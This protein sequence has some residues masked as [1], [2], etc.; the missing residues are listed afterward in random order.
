[1]TLTLVSPP[2]VL[3]V[4]VDELKA[5][6]RVT[7]GAED[8]YIATCLAASVETL[9]GEGDLGRAMVSQTWSQTVGAL[10]IPASGAVMPLDLAGVAELVSVEYRDG[11][12]AW[13]LADLAA[14]EVV[15]HGSGQGLYSRAWPSSTSHPETFRVTFGAGY[16]PAPSDVPAP[17]RHAVK[18]LASHFYEIREPVAIGPSATELPISIDRLISAYRRWLR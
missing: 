1:M 5:H 13:V 10:A 4:S 11:S 3:P 7:S 2:A 12:G 6:L 9:D 15:G 18:L 16:G 17:L 8:D 14:F